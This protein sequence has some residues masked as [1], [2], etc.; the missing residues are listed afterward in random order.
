MN[1]VRARPDDAAALTEIAFVAK[2]HWGYP[3]RWMDGW[4]EVLRVRPDF[5]ARH[6]TYIAMIE[7]RAAAFYGLGPKESR[8]ELVH[9]WVLPA[10]MGRGIGRA[11]FTH[12]VE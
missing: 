2:G 9:L 7:G 3:R 4:R 1:I 12:A 6:E 8:L 11:L 10:A 5:I